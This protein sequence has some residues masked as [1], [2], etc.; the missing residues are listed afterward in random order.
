[1]E[2]YRRM[3]SSRPSRLA[4]RAGRGDI[5][6]HE[7]QTPTPPRRLHAPGQHPHRRLALSRRHAGRQLQP[8]S[9]DQLRPDAGARPVRRLLHGRS[10]G[11][12]EHADGGAEAQRHGDVV[13]SA[14]LAAGA[15][16][17]HQPS[18]PD[19][20]RLDHLRAALHDRAPLRLARPHLRRPRRLE[21]RDHVEPRRRAQFRHGRADGAWRTL[22]PRPRVLRCRD[23][24]L[25]FMGR[26]RLHPRRRGRPLLRSRQAPCAQ[27]QGQVPEG[28]R[29]LEHRAAR[30]GLAGDGAG[31]RVGRRPPA[32]RRDG[33]DGVRG[34]RAPS[35]PT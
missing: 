2:C 8:E 20:H 10:P 4:G 6:C 35:M 14:D 33:G 13:R 9:P 30:P 29:S 5:G 22:C 34:G 26:R 12:A 7:P 15:R 19:R 3:S 18:R 24:P 1:M 23:R 28:A 17:A 32:R 16:P 27:S 31:R 11:R 21:S 25:G